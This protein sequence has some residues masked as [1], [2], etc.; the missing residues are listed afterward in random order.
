MRHAM[1]FGDSKEA[2]R[3]RQIER[4]SERQR[5]RG[6]GESVRVQKRLVGAI[7]KHNIPFSW[8]ILCCCLFLLYLVFRFC[9]CFLGFVF[10]FSKITKEK[11]T[12]NI[13]FKAA[14]CTYFFVLTDLTFKIVYGIN[15]H[16]DGSM[17][18]RLFALRT[19]QILILYIC[20]QVI[21]GY[22]YDRMSEMIFHVDKAH[23]FLFSLSFSGKFILI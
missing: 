13:A 4:E 17:T 14:L 6:D 16:G 21:I 11:E 19:I 22:A 12:S 1:L 10:F 2:Q 18:G 3:D 7:Y 20:T 9:C 15:A 23:A 8:T 5:F